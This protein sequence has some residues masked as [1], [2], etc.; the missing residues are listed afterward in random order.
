MLRDD[1]CECPGSRRRAL[2]RL[3]RGTT[4]YSRAEQGWSSALKDNDRSVRKPRSRGIGKLG[5]R[6]SDWTD[7][8]M[9]ELLQDNDS[10]QRELAGI[11]LAY[12]EKLTPA[13]VEQIR[14]LRKDDRP[15]VRMAAL[16]ALARIEE[17][18]FGT[19]AAGPGQDRGRPTGRRP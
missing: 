19:R 11:V 17:V 1:A 3:D 8:K 16:H 13:V 9:L 4:W 18:R 7:E 12:R 2:A 5:Q 14:K 15:W 10:G 6:A